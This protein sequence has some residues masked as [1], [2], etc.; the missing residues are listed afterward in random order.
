VIE[1]CVPHTGTF[2]W[3]P[4]EQQQNREIKWITNSGNGKGQLSLRLLKFEC[5]RPHRHPIVVRRYPQQFELWRVVPWLKGKGLPGGGQP[6]VTATG[7][8]LGYGDGTGSTMPMSE[9][10][11]SSYSSKQNK[12]GGGSAAT[13]LAENRK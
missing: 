1:A 7:S 11:T 3:P 10:S 9:Y 4:N 8:G 2:P 13:E 5:G 6:L 12:T